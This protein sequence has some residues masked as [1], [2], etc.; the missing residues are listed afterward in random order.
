MSSITFSSIVQ[1]GYVLDI[2]NYDVAGGTTHLYDSNG[3]ADNLDLSKILFFSD[4]GLTQISSTPSFT[5]AEI[6]PVPEPGVVI[7]AL[8]LVGVLL[9]SGRP[10]L[11]RALRR[12]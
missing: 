3:L 6:V 9:W 2:Y 7:S 4:N 1:N 11:V 12:A 5:G 8:M 10:A